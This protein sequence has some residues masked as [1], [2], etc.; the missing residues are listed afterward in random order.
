VQVLSRTV[1]PVPNSGKR[2]VGLGEDAMAASGYR[3]KEPELDRRVTDHAGGGCAPTPRAAVMPHPPMIVF[4]T[5]EEGVR[6]ACVALVEDAVV[7]PELVLDRPQV[8]MLGHVH[9]R[10]RVA[11]RTTLRRAVAPLVALSGS[12]GVVRVRSGP[13]AL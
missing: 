7:G 11:S 6:I 12:S 4:C 10:L 8:A 9:L 13:G 1:L 2:K 3:V 5:L